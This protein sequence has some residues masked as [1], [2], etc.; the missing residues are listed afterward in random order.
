MSEAFLWAAQEIFQVT[1]LCPCLSCHN[2]APLLLTVQVK[3]SAK[4]GPILPN[5]PIC[6]TL[7]DSLCCSF[8]EITVA[9]NVKGAMAF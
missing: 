5:K 7:G 3:S 8:R 6:T 9:M 4:D 1:N 2:L